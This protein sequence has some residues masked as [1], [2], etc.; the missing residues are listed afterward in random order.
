MSNYEMSYPKNSLVEEKSLPDVVA[1]TGA[2]APEIATAD[3]M[4][5]S[6]IFIDLFCLEKFK[7]KKVNLPEGETRFK[8]LCLM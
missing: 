1:K 8:N 5:K 4:V 6:I 7:H 3:Q 2:V